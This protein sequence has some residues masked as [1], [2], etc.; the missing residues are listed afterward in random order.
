MREGNRLAWLVE[1]HL[2]GHAPRG[3]GQCQILGRAAEAG[4]QMMIVGIDHRSA[5]CEV[6]VDG[7]P[8][9]AAA[10]RYA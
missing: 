8:P 3:G 7:D 10:N 6:G 5:A 9:G 1:R 4:E 2:S